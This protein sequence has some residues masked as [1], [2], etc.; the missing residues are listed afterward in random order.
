MTALLSL[1]EAARV[2]GISPWTVRRFIAQGRLQPVQIGRRVL[3]EQS[4]L[5]AFVEAN[6]RS[7]YA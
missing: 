7:R 2:L 3:L 1:K 4:A 5:D 6:R